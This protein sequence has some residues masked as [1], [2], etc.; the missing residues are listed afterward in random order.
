MFDA[1]APQ[2][3]S[4]EPRKDDVNYKQERV[5][6]FTRCK[7][8]NTVIWPFAKVWR[9]TYWNFGGGVVGAPPIQI[10]DVISERAYV[11][12]KLTNNHNAYK[13]IK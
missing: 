10:S 9:R 12:R 13:E 7:D 2:Q 4:A 11:I 1:E 3:D 6:K 5:Y 8:L